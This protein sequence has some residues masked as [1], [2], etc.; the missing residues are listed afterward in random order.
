MV[1]FGSIVRSFRTTRRT[2]AEVTT[3]IPDGV[4]PSS[5]ACR[6]GV[7]AVGPRDRFSVTEVGIEPAVL[8]CRG[9]SLLLP[10]QSAAEPCWHLDLVAFP[11]CVLGRLCEFEKWRVRESHPTVKAYEAPMDTGP[12]AMRET[13]SSKFEIRKVSEPSTRATTI[14]SFRISTFGFGTSTGGL[15]PLELA[16]AQPTQLK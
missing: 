13:R 14:H 11:V 5:P 6:A 3:L 12:P 16:N 7:V 10:Y 1:T 2:R 4:E 9:P 8:S 15:Q